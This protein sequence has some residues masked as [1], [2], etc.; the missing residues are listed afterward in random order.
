MYLL[1]F[2]IESLKV[3]QPVGVGCNELTGGNGCHPPVRNKNYPTPSR[4]LLCKRSGGFYDF[5]PLISV[6]IFTFTVSFRRIDP[7]TKVMAAT[8]IGYHKPA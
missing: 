2:S 4:H 5:F 8:T 1:D 3:A 6:Q 7:T